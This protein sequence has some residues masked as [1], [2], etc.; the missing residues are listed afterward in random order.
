VAVETARAEA[1]EAL[2]AATSALTTEI[3]RAEAAEALLAPL[4]SPA[5]TGAPTATTAA[6][7]TN[8]IRIATTAYAD[9]AVAVETSRAEAAEALK[10]PLASPALTGTPTAPTATAGTNTT[11]LATTAFVEAAVST[12]IQAITT[13]QFSGTSYT[14]QLGDAGNYVE[15]TGALAAYITIPLNSSVAFPYGSG[16]GSSSNTIINITQVGSGSV[17]IQ[18]A[19]GVTLRIPGGGSVQTVAQWATI[20]IRQQAQ[21]V[22]VV[23][24]NDVD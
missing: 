18:G 19:S 22:W 4:A 15:S 2:K 11:Q 14:F 8:S 7:L 13:R 16:S 12:G 1:A 24:N 23:Y 17:T 6:A 20:T 5:L 10:A 9:T 3:S 21:N